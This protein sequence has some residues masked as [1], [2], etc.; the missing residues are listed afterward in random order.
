MSQQLIINNDKETEDLKLHKQ[1]SS[2]QPINNPV[3]QFV[4]QR[5]SSV[6]D[7]EAPKITLRASIPDEFGDQGKALLEKVH[8]DGKQSAEPAKIA[9]TL[10]SNTTRQSPKSLE[11]QESAVA[12]DATSKKEVQQNQIGL[13]ESNIL[14]Q[15]S[16][17]TPGELRGSKHPEVNMNSRKNNTAPRTN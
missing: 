13:N 4:R 3:V 12:N 2:G 9:L 16:P 6:T 5:S 1:E 14:G 17:K 7:L 15:G 10:G 11:P 8:L